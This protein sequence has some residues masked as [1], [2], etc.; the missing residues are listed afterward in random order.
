MKER[1]ERRKRKEKERRQ[2]GKRVGKDL[3][4]PEEWPRWQ[5]PDA[6]GRWWWLRDS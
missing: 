3:L 4:V 5:P 1:W 2:R 6:E